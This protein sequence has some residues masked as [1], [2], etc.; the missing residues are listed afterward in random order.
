MDGWC[1]TRYDP[2]GRIDTVINLP[3][4]RVSSLC[5]GGPNLDTL[6]ITT[7]RRRMLDKELAQQPLAGCVLAVNPGVQGLSEPE[8]LG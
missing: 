4:R 3:T 7:A 5:F 8:F 6:F 2:R 1:V